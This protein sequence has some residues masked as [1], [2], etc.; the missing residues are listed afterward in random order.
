MMVLEIVTAAAASTL[1]VRLCMLDGGREWGVGIGM[2]Y[3]LGLDVKWA[4][5]KDRVL[6][7]RLCPV[8]FSMS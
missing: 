1:Q 6:N 2:G 8:T 5:K 4:N 7:V 3:V